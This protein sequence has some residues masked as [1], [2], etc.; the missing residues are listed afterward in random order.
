MAK[1]S[2]VFGTLLILL[3]IYGFVS[4]GSMH[5]TA[6]IPAWFGAPIALCGFVALAKPA[7]RM[8]VMHAAVTIGLL[9]FIGSVVMVG[10]AVPKL[11]GGQPLERPVATGMQAIMLVLTGIYVALCVRSFITARRARRAEAEAGAGV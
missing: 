3:G 6:L 9:G 2:L 8:H 11:I 10:K 1:I 5:K 4:T 7:L